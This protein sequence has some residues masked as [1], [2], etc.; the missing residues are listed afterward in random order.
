[1]DV[2][3]GVPLRVTDDEHQNVSPVWTP[4][5]RSLL[6]VSDRGG[7]RD[8][9][10]I[11]VDPAGQPLGEPERLTTGLDV[12]T[13]ASSV[14]GH[15]LSYSVATLRQNIWSLP[16]PREGPISIAE[17]RPVTIGNQVV[18]SVGV[19]ADGK[20]LAFGSDQEGNR[21]LLKMP[22]GG[23]EPV[24]LTT[25]PTIGMPSWSPDG[26][27]IAFHT[28]RSDNRDI[29]VISVEGGPARQI[30]NHPAHEFYPHW[31][32]DGTRLVFQSGR[33]GVPEIYVVSK[34]KGELS[35]EVPVQLT[36]DG[37]AIAARWSPDGRLIAYE[38]GSGVSVI[39][40]DGGPLRRLTDFGGRPMWSKDSQTIHFTVGG[41]DERAGI[42]SVSLSGGEPR[43]LVRFDDPTREFY[44]DWSSDGEHFYFMLTEFEAD[45]WVMSSRIRRDSPRMLAAVVDLVIDLV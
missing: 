37:W 41:H 6:F 20:W 1:V 2:E 8:I 27:E 44:F 3:S 7:G 39:P 26:K 43:R 33:T 42:W 35:G 30:T 12:F 10:R 21:S 32:P 15:R 14:D 5:G 38:G 36:F 24:Q 45:V 34:D 17:A 4:D 31:S 28:F 22:V 13:I 29:F 9:Y 23:A 16:V 11:S 19:S 18:E 25:A 40:S